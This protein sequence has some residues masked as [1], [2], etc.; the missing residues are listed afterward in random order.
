VFVFGW[1]QIALVVPGYLKRFTVAHY[2]QGLVPHAM[3]SEG[4]AAVLQSVL[5]ENPPALVC[6]LTLAAIVGVSLFLGVRAV[7]SREYVLDQ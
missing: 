4:I 3:P 1:E 6:I 2:V 5:R 7:E